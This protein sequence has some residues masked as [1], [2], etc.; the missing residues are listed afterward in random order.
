LSQ[1]LS[2]HNFHAQHGARFADFADWLMPTFYTSMIEEHK[3]VRA[4]VGLF[5]VS[6][7]GEVMVTGPDAKK[8]LN[9]IITNDLDRIQKG[10][11]LY[12]PVCYAD[13]GT[14]DDWIV[15]CLDAVT[16][17]ICVNASNRAKDIA[18]MQE[19][20]KSF[21]CELTDVSD[22]YGLLAV[23]G[24]KAAALVRSTF[25]DE[26]I[27]SMAKF[28]FL[29]VEYCGSTMRISRTGYT[30]EDGFELYIPQDALLKTAEAIWQQGQ[31]FG[32]NLCGLGARDS[33]RLEAKMPLYGHELDRHISPV[34][35]GFG[36]AV[37]LDKKVDFIGRAALAAQK[38]GNLQ[39][40]LR[41]FYLDDRR[42]ARQGGLVLDGDKV[43]GTICSGS[44]SP[45]LDKPICSA[46]IKLEAIKAEQLSVDIRG[47]SLDLHLLK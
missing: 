38:Q 6:H 5:D 2:L 8:F 42:I 35:A 12:T 36:W 31:N 41:H 32:I 24:P 3:A 26:R 11:A 14:V 47:K 39:R 27:D 21:D 37:R 17:F 4:S 46:L 45:I 23:Q 29:D 1:T 33:L 9:Y 28:N 43:V 19:H 25:A 10:Q 20:L 34:E 22:D 15:Y 40:C 7:M 18:W 13:G 44:F 30:G 16:F